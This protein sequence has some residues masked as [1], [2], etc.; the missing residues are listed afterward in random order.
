[1]AL[2]NIYTTGITEC[3]E[4]KSKFIKN[5]FN[6]MVADQF[7]NLGKDRDIQVKIA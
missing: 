6:E 7:P 1:M 4:I 3:K 2:I 5:L